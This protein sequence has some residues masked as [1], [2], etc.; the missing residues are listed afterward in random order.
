MNYSILAKS[1]VI[2]VFLAFYD[3]IYFIF[4]RLICPVCRIWIT[5]F[6]KSSSY[7]TVRVSVLE[8]KYSFKTFRPDTQKTIKYFSF[9]LR[10]FLLLYVPVE[11][12]KTF[13]ILNLMYV[14]YFFLVSLGVVEL[15]FDPWILHL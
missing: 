5:S 12:V 7:S 1:T 3:P 11:M 15:P 9:F 13:L 10:F 4:R 6:I 2:M 14:I 8:D